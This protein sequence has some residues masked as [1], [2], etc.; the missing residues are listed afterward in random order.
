MDKKKV[1]HLPFLQK[2][3][4]LSHVQVVEKKTCSA[5]PIQYGETDDSL[6]I[7]FYHVSV[8]FYSAIQKKKFQ[9]VLNSVFIDPLQYWLT[10]LR[11]GSLIIRL[12]LDPELLC[13]Y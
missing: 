5:A 11:S 3:I 9:L 13:K 4:L 10:T 12:C 6:S 2:H 8:E 1:S 7:M